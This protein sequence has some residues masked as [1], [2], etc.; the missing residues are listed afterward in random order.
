MPR[1]RKCNSA[2]AYRGYNPPR[3]GCDECI[4]KFVMMQ[5]DRIMHNELHDDPMLVRNIAAQIVATLAKREL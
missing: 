4:D 5:A 1:L 2:D 3:C